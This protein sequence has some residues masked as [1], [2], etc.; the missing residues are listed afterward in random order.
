MSFSFYYISD[1]SSDSTPYFSNYPGPPPP[2]PNPP[3]GVVI[4][5]G[6]PVQ[7]SSTAHAQS[8]S[9][10]FDRVYRAANYTVQKGDTALLPC[11]IRNLGNESV[12]GAIR[13][14]CVRDL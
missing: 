4:D 12:S 2:P 11:S 3:P 6:N 8:S 5:H 14:N 10:H 9:P 7:P 13:Q 1:P